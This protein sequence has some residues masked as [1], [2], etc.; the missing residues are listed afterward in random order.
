M[1]IILTSLLIFFISVQVYSQNASTYF[2][3]ATGYRWYYKNTPLDTVNLP[4]PD[5]AT[6]QID[7]FATVMDYQGL[8]AS[9]VLSKRGMFKI[10]QNAPYTDSTY[11]NFQSTNA[12]SYLSLLRYIDSTILPGIGGFIR[13]F[14]D[15][16]NV[17]RFNQ[18]VNTNYTIFSR[19]TTFSYDTLNLPLRFSAT[20]RRLND[21]T[22]STINGNYL[23]KK[24]LLTLTISYGLLPPFIY[25]PI[26]TQPDTTYIAQEVWV[27]K[28]IR[29]TINVDLSDLGFPIAF[30]VPGNLQELTASPNGISNQDDVFPSG[31]SLYQNFPNPFNPET[32]IGFRL[33]ISSKVALKVYDALGNEAAILVNEKLPAGNYEIKFDGKNLAS[34]IYFYKLQTENFSETKSMILLK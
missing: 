34:G 15:W 31:F 5:E 22:V 21:Q 13:S 24:F 6:F 27:V 16:Y 18:A 7:S 2:P 29:P 3:S 14:D 1:K 19:D 26:V 4:L 25:I 10:G 17:Y 20:G 28:D 9:V 33:G 32:N 11:Y 12:W 30:S 8:S 23:A